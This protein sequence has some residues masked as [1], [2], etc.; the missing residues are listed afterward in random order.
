MS[1]EKEYQPIAE[2]M[3]KIE[4]QYGIEAVEKA[5]Y[6]RGEAVFAVKNDLLEEDVLGLMDPR[7]P[8]PVMREMLLS[9][10]EGVPTEMLKKIRSLDTPEVTDVSKIRMEYY[11]KQIEDALNKNDIPNADGDTELS[12][13]NQLYADTLKK[14]VGEI[15]NLVADQQKANQITLEFLNNRETRAQDE[16]TSVLRT[17]HEDLLSLRSSLQ[18]KD[19]IIL[20]LQKDLR[21]EVMR[22]EPVVMTENIPPMKQENDNNN[23]DRGLFGFRKSQ[24]KRSSREQDRADLFSLLCKTGINAEQTIVLIDA[25]EDGVPIER[26]QEAAGAEISAERMRIVLGVYGLRTDSRF[27][28]SSI[29]EEQKELPNGDGKDEHK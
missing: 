5:E 16:L 25:F 9:R 1:G 29:K 11:N 4:A 10:S 22:K 15:H 12:V 27:A 24:M 7:L 14:I 26:L 17:Q 20:Q 2:L 28:D 18:S 6:I 8:Q 23:Q 3:K 13:M 19:Q 21:R